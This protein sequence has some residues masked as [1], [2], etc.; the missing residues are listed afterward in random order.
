M[1]LIFLLFIIIIILL[2][3]KVGSK[4]EIIFIVGHAGAGKST[5]AKSL[6]GEV[7]HTDDII[8][9][10]FPEKG[11]RLYLSTEY[12]NKKMVYK[13][14]GLMRK[15]IGNKKVIVEGQLKN[16]NI[17]NKIAAGRPY[18]FIVIVPRDQESYERNLKN[19]FLDNPKEYGHLRILKKLDKNGKILSEYLKSGNEELIKDFIHKG[20]TERYG[21]HAETVNYYKNTFRNVKVVEV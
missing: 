7:I 1:L 16:P 14:I 10:N 12:P 18:R 3:Q 19:R 5:Y 13:F 17:I 21:K 6:S 8:R 15:A 20:A 11:F 9:N 4:E 2:A